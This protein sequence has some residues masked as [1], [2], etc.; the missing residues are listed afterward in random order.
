[1][2]HNYI[3]HSAYHVS[4]EEEIRR[5]LENLKKIGIKNPTKIEASALIAHKNKKAPM[6]TQDV[7]SF[8][9]KLRGLK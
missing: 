3:I 5:I 8:I 7:F 9:S 4:L 1:M 6:K 2:G